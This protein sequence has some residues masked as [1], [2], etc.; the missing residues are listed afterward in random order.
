VLDSSSDEFYGN[1]A[2]AREM[3]ASVAELNHLYPKILHFLTK[4]SSY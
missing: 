2:K 3:S 4:D 1:L